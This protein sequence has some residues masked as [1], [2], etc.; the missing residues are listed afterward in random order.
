[1]T[2]ALL[3]A[4]AVVTAWYA[5][6]ILIVR[7]GLSRSARPGD[8]AGEAFSVIIAARNEE[9]CIG[10]CLGAVLGQSL[11]AERYE[12]IV[13]DDRST[14]R[15]VD[16]VRER[17]ARAPNVRLVQVTECPPGVSPKKNAVQQG[18]RAAQFPV[19]VCTDA[20]SVVPSRWLEAYDRQFA[21][22][23]GVVQGLTL[24]R[25]PKKIGPFL[26]AFQT[27]DFLSHAAISCGSIGAGLPMNANGNNIA[28]RR[29]AFEA[30]GGYG[31]GSDV[32]LGDDDLLLQR[33]WK[34]P[35]W[36]ARFMAD[37]EGAVETE[38]EQTWGAMLQQRARWGSVSI[39][40][41]PAQVF[42]LIGVFLYY[43]LL[44]VPF[45]LAARIPLLLHAGLGMLGVKLLSEA[46]VMLPAARRFHRL[47]ALLWL[48]LVTIPH[49]L[50][51][52]VLSVVGVF[53]VHEW[54]G[55]RSGGRVERESGI[56]QSGITNGGGGD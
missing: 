37:S 31:E 45:V 34:H 16:E 2:T 42:F 32:L 27:L 25:R 39:H 55:L 21:G 20:D 5:A 13:V 4:F 10:R 35:D 41:G 38:P 30:V 46:L 17:A 14:D 3:I 54:K 28:Y 18:I 48:P 8:P 19:I 7:V 6:F 9:Q 36:T 56:G 29:G 47:G 51:V 49:W 1:M 52:L 53:G 15:T 23:V 22:K 40:Y 43:L 11:P 26:W 12:V 44:P 33:V 24:Y 50:M